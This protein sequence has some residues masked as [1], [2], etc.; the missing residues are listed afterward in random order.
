MGIVEQAH[1]FCKGCYASMCYNM[2]SLIWAELAVYQAQLVY[3]HRVEKI[4]S[5]SFNID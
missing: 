2:T 1:M 5:K 3:A 4:V